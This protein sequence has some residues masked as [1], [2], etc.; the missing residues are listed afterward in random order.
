M[1]EARKGDRG[2]VKD[3]PGQFVKDVMRLNKKKAN[4]GHGDMWPPGC[5]Y[6][7]AAAHV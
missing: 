1:E 2:S 4:M 3:V 7:F 5:R 6:R